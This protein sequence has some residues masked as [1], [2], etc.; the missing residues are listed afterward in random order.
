[1]GEE[2]GD[3]LGDVAA[4]LGEDLVG[5]VVGHGVI[6]DVGFD[7]IGVPPVRLGLMAGLPLVLV[8]K[9]DAFYQG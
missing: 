9:R 1:M 5:E 7:V 2:V 6:L 8:Q 3:G 4:C